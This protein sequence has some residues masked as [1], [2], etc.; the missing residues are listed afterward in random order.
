MKN[1]AKA[2]LWVF[3]V[4]VVGGLFGATMT[5]VVTRAHWRPPL[6]GPNR[7]PARIE[8]SHAE[9]RNQFVKRLTDDLGLDPEQ[10]GQI[11]QILEESAQRYQAI[12][13]EK[14]KEYAQVRRET[15]DRMRS[16]LRPDQRAKFDAFLERNREHWR[17]RNP[18]RRE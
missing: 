2:F 14:R 9:Q 17:R 15:L 5:F 18:R 6:F 8:R 10:S 12:S 7:P 13:H 4:F 1:R 16:V 3:L 11:R